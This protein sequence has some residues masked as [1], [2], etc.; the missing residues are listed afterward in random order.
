V[1]AAALMQLRDQDEDRKT[2]PTLDDSIDHEFVEYCA[3][4]A[5]ASETLDEVLQ[6]T[7]TIKDSVARVIIEDERAERYYYSLAWST[8]TSSLT[9]RSSMLILSKH[10]N[11]HGR[12]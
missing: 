10:E 11:C 9:A 7:P 3:R 8:G 12:C 2:V 5:D 6:A 4:Q 1:I